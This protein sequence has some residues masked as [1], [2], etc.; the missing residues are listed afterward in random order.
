MSLDSLGATPEQATAISKI[1]A[2]LH[3]K[4]QPAHDAEKNVLVTLA[5]GMAAGKIDTA[6]VEAAITQVSAAAAGV[7]D[8]IVDS[9][10][11]LHG[12]LTPPQRVALVDKLEAHFKVWHK[13]N[14]EDE[15]QS[16]DAHGGHLG[17]LAK[18]LS[19]SADQVEKIRAA[20]E[21]SMA[22]A[23]THYDAH[24]GNAHLKA[25][26]SAFVSDKFDAKTLGT[27]GTANAHLATWGLTRMTHFYEAAAPVLMPD[28][29]TKLADA[30]RRH[31]NYRRTPTET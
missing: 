16:G 8:A 5:D 7:H 17:K 3:A 28:Q 27:G 24:E 1:Q 11:Q 20:F 9:L 10:N 18:E 14:A 25:F 23:R 22:S 12:T 13:V 21:T 15:P 6:K 31:A 29:R 19:L 30:L 2:D 26:G 4:M